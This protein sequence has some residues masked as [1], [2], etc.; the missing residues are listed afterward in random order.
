M[1]WQ[2][3]TQFFDSGKTKA[4]INQVPIKLSDTKTSGN[5]F[6]EY[7]DYFDNESEAREAYEE[8]LAQ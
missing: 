2:V 1:A 7:I 3:I 6:D 8:A 4:Y 5:N